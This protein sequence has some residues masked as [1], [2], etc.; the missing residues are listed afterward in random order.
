ME[1]N[2]ATAK[3]VVVGPSHSMAVNLS[4]MGLDQGIYYWSPGE[5]LYESIYK[6]EFLTSHL[7]TMCCLVLVLNPLS[8]FQDNSLTAYRTQNRLALYNTFW[9]RTQRME[10]HYTLFIKGKL[11][12]LIRADNWKAPILQILGAKPSAPAIKIS[13]TNGYLENKTFKKLQ[14]AGQVKEQASMGAQRHLSYYRQVN[15]YE[16]AKRTLRELREALDSL[17]RKN[18]CTVILT[19]P[20][21]DEY[22]RRIKAELPYDSRQDLVALDEAFD[23]LLYLDYAEHPHFTDA[24]HYFTDDHMNYW[25]SLAFSELARA[26]IQQFF[27]MQCGFTSAQ[28]L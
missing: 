27:S 26:P 7:Q 9:F 25:G 13:S 23:K 1:A 16:V 12:D 3:T 24:Y 28:G 22:W 14:P 4:V 21:L 2:R 6:A 15:A 10:R 8:V 18:I 11:A 20:Y 5:D 17:D 19:P